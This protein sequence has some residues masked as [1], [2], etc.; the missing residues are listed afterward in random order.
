MS[1][2]YDRWLAEQLRQIRAC[3]IPA[4]TIGQ[5]VNW[6]DPEDGRVIRGTINTIYATFN[7]IKGTGLLDDAW[8][9][10]LDPPA[11]LAK[12]MGPWYSVLFH[13]GGEITVDERR[14][15]EQNG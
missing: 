9:D 1:A 7:V 11:K 5:T 4:F 12:D 8:Y 10:R 14:L 15:L 6:I 13:E 3:P 2:R